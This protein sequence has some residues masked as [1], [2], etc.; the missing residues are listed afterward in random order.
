VIEHIG[1]PTP[2]GTFDA[3]AAGPEDGR[4]VLLLHGFPQASLEWEHQ[5]ATL[6][7]AGYRAVA[8]DQR[9]YSPAVRP[10]R[11]E[12]YALEEIVGDTLAMA[13]ELGWS[14][15]DLVGHDWGGT[16]AW[17][18]AA[19]HA[20]RVRTLTAVST[21]H[22]HALA[23]AIR[24]DEDQQQ[25]SAYMADFRQVRSAERQFLADNATP[26]RRIFEGRI[27]RGHVEEYVQRLS[28]PGALVAALNWYR[29]VKYSGHTGPVTVP[30]M[31]VW[32]TEDPAI[33]STAAMSTEEWVRGPYRFEML[34]DVSHWI[35]EEAD[36]TLSRLLLEHLS[37]ARG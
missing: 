18:T 21:P 19:D 16:I 9:G 30:T 14:R 11:P 10:E 20:D 37:A 31:Y 29:G 33:G 35:P 25:R 2:A 17:A 1:I 6:S 26:L 36:E 27:P 15:F 24:T 7:S 8:P 34:E 28:E 32:S 4:P 3:L 13:D 12:D 22:P 23:R 5:L